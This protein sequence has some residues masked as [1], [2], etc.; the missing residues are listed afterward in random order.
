M[1]N[2]NFSGLLF[3]FLPFLYNLKEGVDCFK[4]LKVIRMRIFVPL[5]RSLFVEKNFQ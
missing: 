3:I 4:R 2:L 1:G 5:L